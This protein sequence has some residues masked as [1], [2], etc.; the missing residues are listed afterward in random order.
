MRTYVQAEEG[1][2]ASLKDMTAQ[3]IS[4]N[5]T[6]ITERQHHESQIIQAR[7]D[8]GRRNHQAIVKAIE[9]LNDKHAKELS[10][11][12][13]LAIEDDQRLSGDL[14]AENERLQADTKARTPR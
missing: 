8:T 12:T 13:M 5:S 10:Q 4:A 6:L 11:A 3:V 9:E 7:E 14:E 1:Y 2:K